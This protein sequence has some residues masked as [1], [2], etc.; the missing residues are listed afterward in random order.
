DY[1]TEQDAFDQEAL[2]MTLEE[3]AMYKRMDKDMLKE[4]MAEE[5]W[6]RNIDYYHPSNWTQEEESFDHESYNK[7]VNTL[8]ANVQTQESVAANMSNRGEIGFRLGDYEAEELGKQL[9][10]PIVAVAPSAEPTASTTHTDK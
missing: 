10:E 2:R 1:E 7:N 9:A 4:Q 8:D 3:K 6:V 5:E